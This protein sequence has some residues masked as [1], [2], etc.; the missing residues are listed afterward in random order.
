[1]AS[2]KYLTINYFHSDLIF[3]LQIFMYITILRLTTFFNIFLLLHAN[4]LKKLIQV[5]SKWVKYRTTTSIGN[6]TLRLPEECAAVEQDKNFYR[7]HPIKCVVCVCVCVYFMA[8]TICG[9]HCWYWHFTGTC[10]IG[11]YRQLKCPI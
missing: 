1:M 5:K 3:Q 11:E 6:V 10:W 8:L 2:T 7:F 9:P 4:A